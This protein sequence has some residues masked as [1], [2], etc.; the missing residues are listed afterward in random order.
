MDPKAY[1]DTW[2]S[3]EIILTTVF[4]SGIGACLLAIGSYLSIFTIRP[5]GSP[6]LDIPAKRRHIRLLADISIASFI[7][8]A[9]FMIFL[10]A[11]APRPPIDQDIPLYAAWQDW[12]HSNKDLDSV[13]TLGLPIRIWGRIGKILEAVAGLTIIIDVIGERRLMTW[14][15]DIRSSEERP[16]RLAR[17]ALERMQLPIAV[18]GFISSG[19]LT[20]TLGLPEASPLTRLGVAA[21]PFAIIGGGVLYTLLFG[22][23]GTNV[24]MCTGLAL[25]HVSH[26]LAKPAGLRAIRAVAVFLFLIGFHFDLLST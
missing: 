6:P 2:E 1:Y 21:Y 10:I 16:F 25:E 19:I 20:L 22:F 7:V 8:A 15:R 23:L 13:R 17:S 3:A 26:V 11:N 4:W 24:V 18:I 5:P 9:F 12:W 14:S